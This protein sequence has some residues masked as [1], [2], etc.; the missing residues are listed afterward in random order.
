MLLITDVIDRVDYVAF[1]VSIH[2][3]LSKSVTPLLFSLLQWH[4][5]RQNKI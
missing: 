3:G 5:Y 2:T 4:V 1:S